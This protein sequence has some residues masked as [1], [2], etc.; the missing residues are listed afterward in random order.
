MRGGRRRRDVE[1]FRM[2]RHELPVPAEMRERQPF[3]LD[4]RKLPVCR[5]SGARWRVPGRADAAGKRGTVA[6]RKRAGPDRFFRS[7]L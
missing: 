7:P 4:A 3:V 1:D 5:A 6:R 2:P